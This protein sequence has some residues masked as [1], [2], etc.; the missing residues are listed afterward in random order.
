MPGLASFP[1][2]ATKSALAGTGSEQD[3]LWVPTGAT[4]AGAVVGAAVAGVAVV[5]GLV[6][7]GR[8]V[9]A[10]VVV[11]GLLVVAGS[12]DRALGGSVVDDALR[13]RDGVVDPGVD[14]D[15]A[16]RGSSI[17]KAS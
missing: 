5:G 6:V 17:R 14:E 8:V 16:A 10:R 12:V 13:G 7:D 9:V 11:G 4:A 1:F 15:G 2:G 3:M